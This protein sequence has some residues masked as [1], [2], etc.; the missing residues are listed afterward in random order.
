M[1]VKIVITSVIINPMNYTNIKYIKPLAQEFSVKFKH[2]VYL[3][4]E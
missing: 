2:I 3:K 4:C 1:L